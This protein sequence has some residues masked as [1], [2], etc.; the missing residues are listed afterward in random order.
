MDCCL[1]CDSGFLIFIRPWRNLL[2]RCCRASDNFVMASHAELSGLRQG[3]RR[4]TVAGKEVW[5]PQEA[6][7]FCPN[8][9]GHIWVRTLNPRN[10]D[11]KVPRRLQKHTGGLGSHYPPRTPAI[12]HARHT[13]AGRVLGHRRMVQQKRSS[14]LLAPVGGSS[15]KVPLQIS[16]NP[17]SQATRLSLL[18]AALSCWH[19]QRSWS[20]AGLDAFH[21]GKARTTSPQAQPS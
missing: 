6:V 18:L 13:L 2:L 21:R 20:A 8:V 10:R 12:L 14:S 19:S 5:S 3:W 16:R 17:G 7:E 15:S 9:R 1:P 11:V 4:I